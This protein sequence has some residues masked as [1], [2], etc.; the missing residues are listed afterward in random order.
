MKESTG[1]K[2]FS[3]SKC[4]KTFR[5]SELLKREE[6][7]LTGDKPLNC[8]QCATECTRV[9]ILKT[10]KQIRTDEKPFSCKRCDYKCK[11]STALMTRE[12]T[13]IRNHSA[14]RNVTTNALHQAVYNACEN[15]HWL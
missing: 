7:V 4:N 10:H 14:A 8:S 11:Q 1:E 13:P 5:K 2:P 12:S 6:R 15:Q 3:S 9:Y